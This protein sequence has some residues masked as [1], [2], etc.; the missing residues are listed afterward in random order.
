MMKSEFTL[1]CTEQR[2][3]SGEVLWCQSNSRNSACTRYDGPTPNT[4]SLQLQLQSHCI[5]YPVFMAVSLSASSPSCWRRTLVPRHENGDAHLDSEVDLKQTW[6][7]V[8]TRQY[9][10]VTPEPAIEFSYPLRVEGMHR[11]IICS[12]WDK[13]LVS[14]RL[15]PFVNGVQSDG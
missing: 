9:S 10:H 6:K 5:L 11:C 14:I 7:A 3:P 4:V 8:S 13:V 1:V 2:I 15:I 12:P